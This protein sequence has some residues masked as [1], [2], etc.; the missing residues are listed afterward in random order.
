MLSTFNGLNEIIP[1]LFLT[2]YRTVENILSEEKPPVKITHILTVAEEL[3]Y[4]KEAASLQIE[5]KQIPADD[6]DSFDLQ[7]YFTEMTDF[8]HQCLLNQVEPSKIVVHCLMGVSRS[9]TTVMA[10]LIRFQGL[11][12][13]EAFDLVK[14]KR[15]VV[16]PND[17][18]L[19]QLK[20]YEK[21]LK[22]K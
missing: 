9:A 3:D 11:T 2:N 14:E 17:G 22:N 1:N 10:Y 15:M 19:D 7:S 5:Y 12:S 4:S 18:F 8:I 13:E 20:K 6:Y 16:S 21:E